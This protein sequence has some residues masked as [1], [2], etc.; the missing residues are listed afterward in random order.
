MIASIKG[1]VLSTSESD[2]V[3]Q[4][5]G[6]GIRVLAP[7]ETCMSAQLGEFV[8]LSTSLIVREESLT[9]YGFE[10]KEQRDFF[11]ILLSVNGVGPRTALSIISTLSLETII[12]AII[13]NH[14]E[15]FCQ[16]PGIG[17]KSAQKIVILL[18][19]KVESLISSQQYLES[20][21]TNSDVLDA[22]INLGYSVV[23]AQVAIQSIPK[24]TEDN[25]ENRLRL[26]LKYF[27]N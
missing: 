2:L 15:I 12:T 18:R 25:L 10:N 4:V 13:N 24:D 20:K 11:N 16:V 14:E 8:N 7:K 3:I 21:D 23:E 27:S 19:D 17:K 5:S 1:E 9:L 26:A 6:I 22:L